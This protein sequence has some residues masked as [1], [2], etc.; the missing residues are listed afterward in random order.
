MALAPALVIVLGADVGTALMARIL[1]FDLSAVAAADIYQGSSFS[2][3]R[4]ADALVSL[5]AWGWPQADSAG[6]GADCAGGRPC[7]ANGVRV[8]FASLTGDII[9]ALIGAVFAIVSYSSLA[10]V[11]LT[12]TLTAAGAISLRLHCVW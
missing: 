9:D 2:L 8:I 6:A 5:D 10:A 1:T 7:Q 11:L 12:A 4:K 3:A